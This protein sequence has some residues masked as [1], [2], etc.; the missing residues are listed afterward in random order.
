[1][2]DKHVTPQVLDGLLQN[3]AWPKRPGDPDEF[4]DFAMSIA[5][6]PMI[7]GEVVRL[8]GGL[9]MPSL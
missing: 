1:M 8:D 3:A 2:V 7:N 6:N 9:R 4:A 5:R